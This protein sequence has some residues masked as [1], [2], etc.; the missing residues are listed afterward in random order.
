MS[1]A[2]Y[3][4]DR[5][6]GD[7]A[8]GQFIDLRALGA[9]V[10]RNRLRLLA[11]TII[12]S[13]LTY[14]YVSSLA[15]LFR[16]EARILLEVAETSFTR[17]GNTVARAEIDEQAV[18]SQVQLIQSRDLA[19]DVVSRLNLA[20]VEEFNP[21]AGGD[22]VVR[23]LMRMAGLGGSGSAR[24]AE[25]RV[26]DAYYERL[27]VYTITGS[28]VIAL[29]FSSADPDLA[30]R[31]AD[32]I[33][34]RYLALQQTV[35]QS[36]TRQASGW[37]AG[38]IER[39]RGRV[40]EA[41][42]RVEEFR[43]RSSLFTS[44]TAETSMASQQL[45]DLNGQ[46]AGARA[47]QAEARTR[48]DLIREVLADGRPVESLDIASAELI[49][50]LSEQ[51]VT[52]QAQLARESQTLLSA[53]P[54]IRELRAQL[55]DL[56]NQI[57]EEARRLARAFENEAR[58]AGARV[59]A[60]LAS[61]ETQKTA[62]AAANEQEV[63]LRALER[64]ARSQRDLLEQFMARYSE[65]TAREDLS[66]L[67][68]DARVISRPSAASAPY[69]PRVLPM[70]L[71]AAFATLLAGIGIVVAAELFREGP[72]TAPPFMPAPRGDEDTGEATPARSVGFGEVK[73]RPAPSIEAADTRIVSDLAA[74]LAGA[75]V[76]DEAMRI[77]VAPVG[78]GV[79]A[80]SLA[81][82][83]A[84]ALSGQAFP[85]SA[86]DRR[87][88]RPRRRPAAGGVDGPRRP[89]R[90]ARLLHPGDPPR[91]LQRRSSHPAGRRQRRRRH[92]R[93]AARH[94][95]RARLYLRLRA[96]GRA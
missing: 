51:S 78:D 8:A 44:G 5:S 91:P 89:D 66:A 60:L 2:D 28:R 35:R 22:G 63:Q 83:L 1:S 94:P 33:A 64:E 50:R 24:P 71:I 67:P 76:G 61:I 84:R 42:R 36:S 92:G 9:A 96:G 90:G 38:E 17:P 14:L 82:S 88:G 72:V 54:R 68:P 4:Y 32:T 56:D 29:E 55:T 46:L 70:T 79:D 13:V 74:Q 57:R 34:D 27:E 21:Q 53:H 39:L 45:A 18:Q 69:F 37:L 40:A 73:P 25:E 62:V 95:R 15:P 30:A 47:T 52:L 3:T 81:L 10:W 19:R 87:R 75:P 85:T 43:A 31:I 16:S 93:P 86:A 41:E 48:A 77:L 26:L 65:A 23:R 58:T 80:G 7:P 49:R 11:V 20:S 6:Y 59:D 12:V